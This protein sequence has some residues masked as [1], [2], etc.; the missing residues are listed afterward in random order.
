MDLSALTVAEYV[1]KRLADLGIDRASY[2]TRLGALVKNGIPTSIHSD[3][4]VSAPAP[5]K[6][7]WTVVTRKDVY[8]D[9]KVWAP[10]EAVTAMDAMK[11]I[12]VDAAYTLGVED[13]VGSIE[14]GK[15]A[16]FT[17]LDSDPLTVP[18][19]KIKDVAVYATV[20]GGKVTTVSE[21]KKPRPLE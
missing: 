10:A 9:G 19:A 14:A 6:E 13:K 17:V 21:T 2:A 20:L 4:P 15:F 1:V 11:M 16:D 8:G 12:T 18:A 3:A 7:V 5:L